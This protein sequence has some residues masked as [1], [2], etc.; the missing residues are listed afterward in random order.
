MKEYFDLINSNDFKN[1]L[2]E[3]NL[4]LISNLNTKILLG[5]VFYDHEQENFWNSDLLK[6]CE[7]K[8]I[9]LY[10]VAKKSKSMVEIGVN[11]GHSSFLCLSANGNLTIIGN[12]IAEYYPDCPRCHPEIYVPEAF[13]FLESKFE[14]RFKSLK[15]N[16][17]T[18]IPEYVKSNLDKKFDL[19]HLDGA[20]ETYKQDFLNLIPVLADNA[21]VVVD[22]YQNPIVQNLINELIQENYLKKTEEFPTMDS[23]IK[24]RNEILCFV[25]N[26]ERK[27]LIFE[28][29]YKQGI[30]NDN[31][32]HIPRSG[33]GS[34]LEQTRDIRH[35]LNVFIS[36][37]NINTVLDLG[38]G[39]LTWIKNTNAFSLDYT[40]IDITESL[41]NE[42]KNNYPNKKFYNKDIIND[43]IPE[44]DL[45][46]IR[47]VIFHIKTNDI[48][49][50]FENIKH[51]FKYLVITSCNNL[52]NENIH[53][54]KYHYCQVNLEIEP[55]N[56]IKGKIVADESHSNRKVLLFNHYDFYE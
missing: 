10:Q 50:L 55:F 18:V 8:R 40:G 45:I 22:D 38:C 26:S 34:S 36:G 48:I 43:E 1:N 14:N 17:L 44:A 27:K 37:N 11:G 13:K 5:N 29:I 42:H 28:N 52:I 24:Y 51:K 15:G 9:R 19:V 47:D 21:L 31:L 41:I 30:W 6:D 56:K 25:N 2:V 53:E 3:L 46:I 54:N 20:K 39:D 32:S 35:F 33:P 23:S 49:K 4:N 16:C 12:D 7:E